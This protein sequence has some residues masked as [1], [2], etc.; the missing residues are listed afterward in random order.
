M[1][2][3][4]I[5]YRL[6]GNNMNGLGNIWLEMDRIVNIKNDKEWISNGL[7][8]WHMNIYWYMDVNE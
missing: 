5:V 2:L 7:Y 8:R 4:W 1:D 3:E 6:H